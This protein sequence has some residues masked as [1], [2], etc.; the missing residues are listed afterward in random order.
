MITP[1]DELFAKESEGYSD[2][3]DF[4]TNIPLVS[5]MI[6][7]NRTRVKDLP[8]DDKGRAI[9]SI[10]RPHILENMSYFTVAADTFK[11]EGKYCQF[12][13]SKAPNSPYRKFWDEEIRRCKEGYVREDGEWITGYYYYYLNY[14]PIWKTITVGERATSGLIQ[15]S[16]IE[17]FP[18]VWDGDYLFFHYCD[19]AIK[20]GEYGTVLKA[21]GKGYSFKAGN[22][23]QCNYFL[24]PGSKS[25]ALAADSEYLDTDGILNKADDNFSFINEHAGFG[26]KLALKDTLMH[27]KAGYKKPGEVTEYGTKSERI[28]V[29]LKNKPDKAR[30][31]RGQLIVVE[32]AGSFPH[33]LKSWEL[34]DSSLS[35]GARVFG[36]MLAFGT[37][38]EEGVSFEG[39]SQLFYGPKAYKIFGVKNVFD[40]NAERSHCSFFV[41]DYLNR[42]DCY[43]DNGNSDVTKALAEIVSRRVEIK[44]SSN[45]SRHLTQHKAE[46]PVTP[47]EAMMRTQGS[48]FP[49]LELTDH[50][51]KISP[52]KEQFIANHYVIDITWKGHCLV[53]WKPIFD[54][55]P[56]RT[57][58][59]KG[60]DILGA[61][62]VFE[63]PKTTQAGKIPWGRYILGIDPVDDDT[64][65]TQGISLFNVGVFDLWDDVFVAEYT[66][67][68]PKA[69]D[70]YDI[71][72]KLAVMYNAEVNYENKL[73]G[74]FYHFNKKNMLNYLMD[75]PQILRDMEYVKDKNTFGNKQKGSPPNEQINSFARRQQA[76]W[77]L[78]PIPSREK[79][80]YDD[81]GM[82]QKEMVLGYQTLRS[83][84]YIQECISWNKDGNFDRVS[85]A[86]MVFIARADRF[87]ITQTA[88][89]VETDV[90]EYLDDPF[91]KN[92][93]GTSSSY[94]S[95]FGF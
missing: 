44:Y 33:L 31:K 32:E 11:R 14:C 19:Q 46:H 5:W 61:I 28:G 37:G 89:K 23:L 1:I 26:K 13:P 21:R 92:N 53:D 4:V 17:G 88:S 10:H 60:R 56:I 90:N 67:R 65:L 93:M 70:N 74:L 39:L 25:Y 45:D 7:P 29:T 94:M 20:R 2:L 78:S 9:V 62:E 63:L 47:Q 43:D 55:H 95:N 91:F 42:A 27:R 51:N 66:G 38:G 52:S 81:N 57:Y 41:P 49:T 86:N 12:Y 64:N 77:M 50:L 36:F 8:K 71:A 82:L 79:T 84:G 6:D 69:S 83:F 72:A 22:M 35:D 54:K 59:Y 15:S 24:Y 30:G 75:T 40:K 18:D 16:R 80:T 3:L 73:K 34:A 58:P 87:K 48:E 68:Y 85:G 76:E